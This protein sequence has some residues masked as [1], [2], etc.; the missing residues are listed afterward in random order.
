MWSCY[1]KKSSKKKHVKAFGRCVWTASK[2][3]GGTNLILIDDILRGK[4]PSSQN[5]A[6]NFRT[7]QLSKNV[8]GYKLYPQ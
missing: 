2:L 5:G 6:I 4:W 3:S 7:K 8:E 1:G